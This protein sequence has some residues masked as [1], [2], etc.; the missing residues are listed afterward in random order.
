MGER[1]IASGN[2]QICTEDFGSREDPAILLIMGATASM[3]WWPDGFCEMLAARGRYVIR[4]DNRDTGQSTTYPPGQ[5][6]YSLDDMAEDAFRVL[7]AYDLVQAHL[8]GMSLGGML[9]QIAALQQPHRVATLTL[10]SSSPFGPSDTDLPGIDERILEHHKHGADVNWEDKPAVVDYMTS[11]WGLLSG[12]AH[13]FDRRT[14]EAIATREVQRAA[15]L[16]SMFNHA[17]LTGGEQW[18]GRLAE[19]SQPVLVIHGTEDPVLP[20]EHGLALTRG[21]PGASLLTMRGTGHELH[22]ADWRSMVDAI[23]AHTG[24][25]PGG[26]SSTT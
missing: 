7:D 15:N 6:G 24:S 21:I 20:Y 9:A 22:Q 26:A 10:I 4:F 14:I 18:Y 11:G 16:P 12:S 23:C 17:L 5:P 25:H 13:P 19:I 3:V 1:I 8:V 2:V